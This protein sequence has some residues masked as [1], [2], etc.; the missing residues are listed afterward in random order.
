[1]SRT[2]STT[3]YAALLSG[4]ARQVPSRYT[5]P[6]RAAGGVTLTTPGV[7][8]NTERSGPA[9]AWLPITTTGLPAPAGKCRASAASPITELG[10]PRNDSAFVSPCASSWTIPREKTPRISAVTTH[11]CLLYTS[12]A[13]DEEDSVD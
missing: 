3:A 12:D 1:M 6:L 4:V 10:V 9:A 8:A 13:A 7:A 2:W 5:L 11:T